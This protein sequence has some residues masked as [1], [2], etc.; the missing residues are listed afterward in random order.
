MSRTVLGVRRCTVVYTPAVTRFTTL[1]TLGAN[2]SSIRSVG[3]DCGH[4]QGCFIRSLGRLK[5][6]YR[7][8][9]KTFCT[10]PSVRDAK[11]SSRRFTR[12]LLLRRGMTI[13]PNGVFNRDKR[14]RIHYSCTAS[15]RLLR[16]TVGEVNRFLGQGRGTWG[17]SGPRR[18]IGFGGKKV[19]RDLALRNWP[20]FSF[21]V[22]SFV[23]LF[24][25]V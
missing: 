13:I 11:L 21:C 19:L 6:A 1:R 8:P 9:N 12:G 2:E 3:G 16:R 22:L 20:M 23:G 17:G 5:L 4:E 18:V 25:R 15:V 24:S 10:F 7:I 14:N